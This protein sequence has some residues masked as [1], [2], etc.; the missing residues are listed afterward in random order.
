M[1]LGLGT[2]QF[3]S[4]YGVTNAVGKVPPTEVAR[5]LQLAAGR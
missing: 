2:A 4:D 1:R 3:G 5:M